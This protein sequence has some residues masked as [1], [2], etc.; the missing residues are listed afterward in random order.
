MTYQVRLHPKVDK[1]LEKC[2][3]ELKERALKKFALLKENP[4]Q[5]LEHYEGDDCHKLRIGDYRAL[6]DVDQKNQVVFVRVF[7]HRRRI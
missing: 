7:D 4:F 1:F 5:Y 2:E 6:V 3:A